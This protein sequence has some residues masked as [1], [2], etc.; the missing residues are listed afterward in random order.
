MRKLVF[1]RF[2]N[3]N[4]EASLLTLLMYV[5]PAM[6]YF[7]LVTFV[8]VTLVQSYRVI[9]HMRIVTAFSPDEKHHHSPTGVRFPSL[10]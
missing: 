6:T 9:N 3:S 8:A 10:T 4:L 7:G 2:E 1:D 5:A